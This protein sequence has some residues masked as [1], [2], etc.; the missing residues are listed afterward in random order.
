MRKIR[1]VAVRDRYHH[2]NLRAALEDAV[3]D[4]VLEHGVDAVTMAEAARRV[5]VSP[6]APYRHFGSLDELIAATATNSVGRFEAALRHV[7]TDDSAGHG[8]DTLL[9]MMPAFFEFARKESAAFAL[10]FDS[11]SATTAHAVRP[12]MLRWFDRMQSWVADAVDRPPAECR[13]LTLAI[14]GVALGQVRLLLA[15]FSPLTGLDDA[16]HVT[17]DG[18]NLILTG[19]RVRCEHADGVQT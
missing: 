17:L 14:S 5:G 2:G 6:S 12:T 16:T 1:H 11:R 9:V 10:I 19:F 15:G 3:L 8:A 18:I 7:A 4:I 13:D